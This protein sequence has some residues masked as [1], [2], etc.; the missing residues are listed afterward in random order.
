M[1]P[2][3]GAGGVFAGEVEG[4]DGAG[5]AAGVVGAEGGGA[6]GVGGLHPGVVVP[7][8]QDRAPVQLQVGAERGQGARARWPARPGRPGGQGGGRAGEGAHHRA[9]RRRRRRGRSRSRTGRGPTGRRWAA[10]PGAGA[11]TAWPHARRRPAPGPRTSRPEE[12][13][14]RMRPVTEAARPAGRPRPARRPSTATRTPRSTRRPRG[15]GRPGARPREPLGQPQGDPL[16]AAGDPQALAGREAG[17]GMAERGGGQLGDWLA[18]RHLQPAAMAWRGA[19]SRGS[20]ASTSATDRSGGGQARPLGQQLPEP[21][22]L[23]QDPVPVDL[24]A[25]AGL[26]VPS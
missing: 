19:S 26:A 16:V 21:P 22:H 14:K 10:A 2:D 25:A 7:G 8:G 11:R 17:A 9:G 18:G 24:G 12:W 5:Q 15:R 3:Q 6:G 20:S 1:R 4:A 23:G 13:S